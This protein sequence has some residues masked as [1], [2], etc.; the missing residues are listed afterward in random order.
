MVCEWR[1]YSELSEIR[2]RERKEVVIVRKDGRKEGE[3]NLNTTSS[4]AAADFFF[5][6]RSF[7]MMMTT[8]CSTTTV[9][10]IMIA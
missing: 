3:K 9:G 10:L 7:R 8:L 5:Q 4:S 2:V 1:A 6:V